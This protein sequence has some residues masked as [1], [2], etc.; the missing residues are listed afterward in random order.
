MAREIVCSF[1]EGTGVYVHFGIFGSSGR[2][3][4][5]I[6]RDDSKGQLEAWETSSAGLRK[7]RKD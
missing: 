3:P 7:G 4:S 2:N 6:P 5:Q 1:R